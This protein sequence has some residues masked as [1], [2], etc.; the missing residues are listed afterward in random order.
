MNKFRQCYF[1]DVAGGLQF[2]AS[3]SHPPGGL[4]GGL[5]GLKE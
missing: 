1:E 2:S 5:T 3:V 4:N